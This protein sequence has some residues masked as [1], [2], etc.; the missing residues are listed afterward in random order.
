MTKF[1]YDILLSFFTEL[2]AYLL[3]YSINKHDAIDTLV[4]AVWM[5]VYGGRELPIKI[6]QFLKDLIKNKRKIINRN[7]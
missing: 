7:W 5:D 6:L 1:V 3:S 4:L 2:K